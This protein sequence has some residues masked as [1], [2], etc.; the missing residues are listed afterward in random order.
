MDSR[1]TLQGILRVVVGVFAIG[2]L[3]FTARLAY[4]IWEAFE[5]DFNDKGAPKQYLRLVVFYGFP[6]ILVAL[7]TAGSALAYVKTTAR[8]CLIATPVGG[9]CQAG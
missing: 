9:A 6:G 4:G 2:V 3:A 7:A 1:K 5:P 8:S